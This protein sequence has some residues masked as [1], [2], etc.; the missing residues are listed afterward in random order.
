MHT[1]L[2]RSWRGLAAVTWD[3]DAPSHGVHAAAAAEEECTPTAAWL[4]QF[5]HEVDAADPRAVELFRDWPLLPLHKAKSVCAGSVTHAASSSAFEKG[6]NVARRK[7]RVHGGGAAGGCDVLVSC[8]LAP[9]VLRV[10]GALDSSRVVALRAAAIDVEARTAHDARLDALASALEE[11]SDEA[12]RRTERDFISSD[13]SELGAPPDLTIS[14]VQSL[15][16]LGQPS[17]PSA[18]FGIRTLSFITTSTSR[19]DSSLSQG[20]NANDVDDLEATR[21]Q[22]PSAAITAMQASS[23]STRRNRFDESRSGNKSRPKGVT[24]CDSAVHSITQEETSASVIEAAPSILN[25]LLLVNAPIL[26]L[27]YLSN[28][29]LITPGFIAT[30]PSNLSRAVIDCL[31]STTDLSHLG[32]LTAPSATAAAATPTVASSGINAGGRLKGGEQ[33]L[34]PRWDTLFTSRAHLELL[35]SLVSHPTGAPTALPPSVA[36]KVKEIPP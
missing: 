18:T 5:W 1:V 34:L 36:E 13:A 19:P 21:L 29:S 17:S 14:L 16:S 12:A 27:A 10:P 32:A 9:L 8:D 30:D 6:G 15:S 25:M 26:E 31:A 20:K 35:L 24:L 33:L 7:E 4:A 23:T 3:P 28:R 22:C 11:E 2:P